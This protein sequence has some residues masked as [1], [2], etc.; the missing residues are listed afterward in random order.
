[1]IY[2]AHGGEAHGNAA[3]SAWHAITGEWYIALPLYLVLL[4]ALG[5]VIYL[6]SKS[7]AAVF[8]ILLAVLFVAGVLVY[9]AAPVVSVVSLA[10][11]FALALL[12]VITNLGGP[13]PDKPSGRKK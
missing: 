6:V 2:F 1:M 12:L 10:A 11:G 7:R 5:T 3:Q 4:F 9:S 13:G 8:N